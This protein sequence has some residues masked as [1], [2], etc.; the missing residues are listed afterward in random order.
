[1]RGSLLS[2]SPSMIV[3]ESGQ[4]EVKKAREND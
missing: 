1:M 4:Q 3:D 2:L